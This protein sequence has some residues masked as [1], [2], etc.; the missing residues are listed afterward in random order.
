MRRA[1]EAWKLLG[2][3]AP[4]AERST[5][6]THATT[7]GLGPSAAALAARQLFQPAQ[8][9]S[10]HSMQCARLLQ[11][12]GSRAGQG[13]RLYQLVSLR[14][15][16]GGAPK[17]AAEETKLMDMFTKKIGAKASDQFIYLVRPGSSCPLLLGEGHCAK[18]QTARAVLCTAAKPQRSTWSTWSSCCNK[19]GLLPLPCIIQPK[20]H[21]TTPSCSPSRCCPHPHPCFLQTAVAIAM[22][23][24]TYGAVPLYRLF[25]QATGY[26]G[27]VQEGAT[28][29][30]KLKARQE[31]YDAA[32]EEACANREITVFFNADVNDNLPWKFKPTQRSVVV[33]GWQAGCRVQ[34]LREWGR[35]SLGGGWGPSRWAAAG[36]AGD[37]GACS[38]AAGPLGGG[39]LLC[40]GVQILEGLKLIPSLTH[41][42]GKNGGCPSA[43]RSTPGRAH[44]RSTPLRT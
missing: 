39:S 24:V 27:T 14:Q 20:G 41:S 29:E 2:R 44:W 22:V 18:R 28:V 4:L 25:C 1:Q 7:L 21:V 5:L 32:L 42:K 15:L 43:C 6:T 30:A 10:L 31:A 17:G 35:G 16:S 9:S 40:G 11:P 3:L 34:G 19:P 37:R 23:G 36:G 8:M 33:G 38:K 13:R 12:A 26:G